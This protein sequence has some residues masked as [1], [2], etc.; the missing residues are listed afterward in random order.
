MRP[1]VLKGAS[2]SGPAQHVEFA[3]GGIPIRSDTLVTH[4]GVVPVCCV[5]REYSQILGIRAMSSQ[6]R[7]EHIS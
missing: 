1:V 3:A 5:I 7:W 4:A 6:R 2:H